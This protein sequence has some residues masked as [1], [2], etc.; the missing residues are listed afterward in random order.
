LMGN[1]KI[2][3]KRIYQQKVFFLLFKKWEEKDLL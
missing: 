3:D 1:S 2:M